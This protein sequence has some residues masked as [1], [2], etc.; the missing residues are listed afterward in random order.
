MKYFFA[1][2]IVAAG[3]YYWF[4]PADDAVYKGTGGYTLTSA[5]KVY[6]VQSFDYAMT[7]MPDGQSHSWESFNG[8]GAISPRDL[9]TSKSKSNCR[10]FSENYTIGGYSGAQ[11]GIA[12]KRQGRDGWCRIKSGNPET[13]ALEDTSIA[14]NFGN[15]NLGTIDIGSISI[16]NVN[17]SVPS[18]DSNGVG[19]VGTPSM[20]DTGKKDSSFLPK[21]E[22]RKNGQTT[23]DW[24]IQD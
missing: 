12:C 14:I 24:L 22:G 7:V 15:L 19:H 5:E 16:G 18:V 17:V 3:L 8:K 4:K 21:F 9:Y 11:D 20:P 10:H 13:C 1:I 6:Y 2:L 23:A